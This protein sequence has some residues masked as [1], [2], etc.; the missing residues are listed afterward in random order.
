LLFLKGIRAVGVYLLG[1]GCSRLL[2]KLVFIWL[3]G[4][5][6]SGLALAQSPAAGESGQQDAVDGIPVTDALVV[7]KCSGCHRKDEKGN[8]TRISWERTTPEG[9]Q[10][11]V[12][13]MVR[14][15]GL[16]LTPD[17]A[18]AVV[19]SLSASHGLAPEEAKPV[20]YMAEHTLPDE[21]YPTPT[22]RTTCGSC[23]AFGRPA[24]WRRSLE[25]WKLLLNMHIGYYPNAEGAA[26]WRLTSLNASDPNAGDP[27]GTAALPAKGPKLVDQAIDFLS[28]NYAL[29]TPEWAAWQAKMRAPKLAGTWL[30]KG[31]LAGHG[32]F[33]GEMVVTPGSSEDEFNTAIKLQPVAGGA[34]IERRG[35]AVVY[36]GYAWRG[37]S[38]GTVSGSLPGD[39]PAEMHEALWIS[40]D[41][42]QAMG[43]WFW[44]SYDEFGFDVKLERASGA[45][46]LLALDRLALKAG[47]QAQKLRIVGDS[48]PNQILPTDID[49]GSGVTVRNIVSHSAHD[50]VLEVD[51]A[52]NAIPGKRDVVVGR[53]TLSNAIA[54]Y[55]H[56]DYIKVLPEN[57]LSRLGGGSQRQK[58]YRQFEA[59]A[60]NRGA[61][62]QPNTADD[63][64]LGPVEVTWSVEEFYE[65]F[66]DDDKEFVGSLSGTGLFTPAL[67]GPNPQRKQ[68]RDNYGNVWVVG[69]AKNE[70]DRLGKPLVGKSYLVVAPPLYVIWDR[71]IDQ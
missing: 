42:S 25:E 60:Y 20:M 37:R 51:V 27:G 68:S 45:P 66:D 50:V 38:A 64:E 49:L 54:V 39:V 4:L 14:S 63:I 23:H 13:R 7:A 34:L 19:K 61:D 10:E 2:S 3:A 62:N 6:L 28:K 30:V 22:M 32:D 31:H 33:Y 26:A 47:S 16:Q 17:E 52:A 8:L 41:E 55:D 15:N 70:K 59:V 56:V 11:V 21:A 35:R 36:S 46:V 1:N 58:G 5:L 67:D 65:R 71:E 24:S 9:W 53:A 48:L 57:S 44:G 18:R 12:K 29:H 69:T 43:R 40:T